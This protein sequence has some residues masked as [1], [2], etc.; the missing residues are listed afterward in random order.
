MEERH[1]P[2]RPCFRDIYVLMW[3]CI[4]LDS[5]RAGNLGLSEG[6]AENCKS[7]L[8]PS[9]FFQHTLAP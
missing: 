1:E 9:Y 4:Y 3:P 5:Q 8:A 6:F 2:I 7:G